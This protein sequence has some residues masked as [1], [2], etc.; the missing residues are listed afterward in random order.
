MVDIAVRFHIGEG[1]LEESARGTKSP[2][3]LWML[4][5]GVLELQVDKGPCEL[6]QPLVKGI[7]GSPSLLFQ[8]EML[9]HIVGLVIIAQVEALEIAKVA[10]IKCCLCP[11]CELPT[12][13]FLHKK[14]HSI[15]FFHPFFIP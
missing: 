4:G 12:H 11:I 6:D 1:E 10:G 15:R 2:A 8:P 14:F 3:V 9:Q 7:I 5:T 13:K